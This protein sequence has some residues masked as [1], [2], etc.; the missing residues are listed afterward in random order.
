MKKLCAATAVVVSLMA[1]DAPRSPGWVVIPVRDY[2]ALRGKAF[3]TELPP[4]PPA[5]RAVLT[6]VDYDLR[7]ESAVATGRASLTVDVLTD[8]WVR[9]PIPQGLLVREARVNGEIV[10]L[11]PDR[12]GQLTALLSRRGRSVLVLDVAFAVVSSGGE[13]RL[14]LPSGSSGITSAA[15]LPSAPDVQVNVTGGVLRESSPTRWLAY[16][17]GSE[18]LGFAWRKKIEERREELPVRMKASLTQLFGAGD[19]GSTLNAEVELEVLQGAATELRLQVPAA[20]TI[21]QVP[22]A[23]VADWD[24][25]NGELIIHFLDPVDRA[26]KFVI[27]AEA[28]LPREGPMTIPLLQVLDVERESGGVAVEILG[29]GEIKAARPQGLDPTD[30]A[31]L[32]ASIAARQ[33]PSL[34]AFRVRAGA[35]ARSLSLDVARYAQQAVLTANIEEARYRILVTAEGKS[36]VQA[37]YAVRNNQRNFVGIKLPAGAQVWSSSLAGR[38]VRPGE[39]P[40]GGLLFPLAKGRAGDEAPP[41]AIEILYALRGAEW[42]EKGHASLGLPVLDL[43]VSRT[44]L[45]LYFPPLYRLSVDPGAFRMQNYEAVASEVLN[46]STVLEN[47]ALRVNGSPAQASTQALIEQYRNRAGNRKAAEAL[48]ARVTFPSV[49]P[50]AFLVSELTSEGQGAV[51][52]FSYQKDKKG[53]V[54]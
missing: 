52:E 34:S 43:P 32:G 46:V 41:F 51:L 10:S 20:L 27:Q 47:T 15:V 54:K 44:G 40:N 35:P 45:V 24:V 17:K 42:L 50:S 26:A 5:A 18:P 8:G 16:A 31:E 33:S 25:R 9:V 2:D 37:R 39:A 3:P 29:A 4:E 14:W 48:P 28:R 30:A 19:D 21:N 38:P 53:G 11:T 1:Q 49:G 36:L 12:A 7:V 22:G 13:E 6:R 23:N